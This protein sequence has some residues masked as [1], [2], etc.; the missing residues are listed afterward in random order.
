M[1]TTLAMND[2]SHT[3]YRNPSTAFAELVQKYGNHLFMN[4]LY[5]YR[6][7]GVL[8]TMH[9]VYIGKNMIGA[10]YEVAP[11]NVL[12]HIDALAFP[13]HYVEGRVKS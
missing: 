6:V 2:G 9:G 3:K 13:A 1:L 10:L 5:T 8:V 11:F 4:P 7:S 12:L